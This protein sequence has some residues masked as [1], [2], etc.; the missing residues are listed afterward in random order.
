[1]AYP[2]S[3]LPSGSG[4]LISPTTPTE[5]TRR[6]EPR[7]M[8]LSDH[9]AIIAAMENEIGFLRRLITP[10][11]RTKDR[12]ATGTIG[13]KTIMLL[14]TGVGP[15]KTIQRL[16]ETEWVHKPQCVLSIGC[17]GALSPQLKPGDTVIPEKIINDTD[18]GRFLLP[19]SDL[20]GI[21]K[22]CCKSL[23]LSYHSGTTVSTPKAAAKIE[24]KRS[25][26]AKYGAIA[27]D[28]ESAQVAEWAEKANVP[29]LAIRTIADAL[30]DNIPPETGALVD[31]RGKLRVRR[32][33]SLMLSRPA[34]FLEI[35][36]LKRNLDFS[37]NILAKIVTALIRE[38]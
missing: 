38:T 24:E 35:L 3:I 23:D 30:G 28:M 4:S 1:M 12:Y 32:T 37:L 6:R 16:N 29:M 14:R 18:A 11:S 2:P 34:F 13:S 5:R 9:I 15:Q 17:A 7:L 33:F 25:L 10:A 27:V 31:A 8:P 36:R 20:I 21:A 22:K 19:S 26:A